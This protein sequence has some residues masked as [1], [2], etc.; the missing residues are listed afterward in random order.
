MEQFNKV[1]VIEEDVTLK[2]EVIS[3]KYIRSNFMLQ[4]ENNINQ[5]QVPEDVRTFHETNEDYY[6]SIKNR[7]SF[8]NKVLTS[9]SYDAGHKTKI[10]HI[11]N[12]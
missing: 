5:N 1:P 3:V 2:K 9:K 6:K 12:N 4:K 10:V 8:E 7:Q 11:L